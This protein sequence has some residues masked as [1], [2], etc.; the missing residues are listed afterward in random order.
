MKRTNSKREPA[1]SSE[2]QTHYVL[3]DQICKWT[4]AASRAQ[5]WR[6][7]LMPHVVYEIHGYPLCAPRVQRVHHM[8]D[9]NRTH[10]RIVAQ[11]VSMGGPQWRNNRLRKASR[12]PSSEYLC[13]HS[14]AAIRMDW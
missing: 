1:P 13:A 12:R 9:A 3:V 2:L 10:T 4:F 11:V 6:V 14:A 7:S 5:I 8:H